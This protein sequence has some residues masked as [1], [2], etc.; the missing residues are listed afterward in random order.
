MKQIVNVDLNFGIGKNNQLL[1]KIPQDL[2]FFKAQTLNK[3]VVMG[4]S[5]FLS[6][7]KQQPLPNRIN[8]VLT[9]NLDFK[10]PGIIV[11]NSIEH[12][13]SILKNYNLD[14]VY[15]IGGAS[16]YQQLLPYCNQLLV[17]K[18]FFDF[19]ADRFYVNLN[20]CKDF[21]ITTVSEMFQYQ[22][23]Q[24]QFLTYERVK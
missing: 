20:E 21:K 22:Q 6:F 12:L 24:Y 10:R 19:Q 9:S 18:T 15:V 1:V 23:Y 11:A 5:T 8:I 3:I 7:P 13:F 16:I 2:A 4:K 14:D 17:T